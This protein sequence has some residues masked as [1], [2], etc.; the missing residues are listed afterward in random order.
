M[1]NLKLSLELLPTITQVILNSK[2]IYIFI[3]IINKS[4]LVRNFSPYNEKLN[5]KSEEKHIVIKKKKNYR[6]ETKK[7]LGSLKSSVNSW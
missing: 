3:I 1:R 6:Y 2:K 4:I 5:N 7:V